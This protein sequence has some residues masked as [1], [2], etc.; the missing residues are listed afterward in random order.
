MHNSKN[1]NNN[2]ENNKVVL[3]MTRINPIF[4]ECRFLGIYDILYHQRP[5]LFHHIREVKLD[6]Q[7]KISLFT[8]K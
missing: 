4:Q 7:P 2:S 3:H 8:A 6:R 5:L 1:K